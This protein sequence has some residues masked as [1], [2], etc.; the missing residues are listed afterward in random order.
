MAGVN[1]VYVIML[2]NLHYPTWSPLALL[3]PHFLTITTVVK[4]WLVAVVVLGRVE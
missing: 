1:F 3:Q 2:L 4:R